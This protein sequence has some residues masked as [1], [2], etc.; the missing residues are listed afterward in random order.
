MCC[1]Y[2]NFRYFVDIRRIFYH[3][4]DHLI[5]E[6]SRKAIFLI[7]FTVKNTNSFCDYIEN[8]KEINPVKYKTN[9]N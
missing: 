2:L 5:Y 6:I 1:S 9:F 7:I 4:T 8:E 3:Q